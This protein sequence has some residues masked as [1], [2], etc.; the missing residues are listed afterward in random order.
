MS[1]DRKTAIIIVICLIGFISFRLYIAFNAMSFSAGGDNKQESFEFPMGLPAVFTGTLPCASCPGIDTHLLIDSTGFREVSAYI[2]EDGGPVATYG[3]WETSGADSLFLSSNDEL[4]KTYLIE[5]DSLQLLDQA[6]NRIE[7][8]LSENYLLTYSDMETQIRDRHEEFRADGF[9]FIASGNG[10][11]WSVRV[12]DKDYV[13]YETPEMRKSGSLE[14]RRFDESSNTL[15]ALFGS[16][17]TL[18]LSITD[19]VCRDSMSGFLFSHTVTLQ[20]EGREE[21]GCGRFL[22]EVLSAN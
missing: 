11:F 8:D 21:S 3:T 16:G 18:Q 10:P 6:G 22:N 20:Y 13:I 12:T 15:D 7:G 14:Q 17:E 5:N 19:E 9:T 1:I 2:D 4:Y